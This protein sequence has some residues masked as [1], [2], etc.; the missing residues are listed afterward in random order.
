M[1]NPHLKRNEIYDL[2]NQKLWAFYFQTNLFMVGIMQTFLGITFI[3][4]KMPT[5][6]GGLP[7]ERMLSIAR[8]FPLVPQKT[9]LTTATL[10]M[11]QS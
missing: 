2:S 7:V 11:E 4:P 8:I 6:V 3:I 1:D 9:P 10:A 5:I